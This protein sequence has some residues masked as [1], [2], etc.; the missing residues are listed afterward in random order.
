MDPIAVLAVIVAP[1]ATVAG[2]AVTL[3]HQRRQSAAQDKRHLRDARNARAR[4]ALGK[5]VALA[6]QMELVADQPLLTTPAMR[7]ALAKLL[8]QMGYSWP[9]MLSARAEILCEPDGEV[10]MSEFEAQ[11]LQPFRAVREAAQQ[12]E[13]PREPLKSLKAGVARFRA[14]VAA[15]LA[16][17]ERP[18]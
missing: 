17:L 12:D 8:E 3:D 6:L 10:W 4:Q 16:D 5:L 9:E 15:H 7:E 11:V 1:V 2:V 18:L 13:D 14:S